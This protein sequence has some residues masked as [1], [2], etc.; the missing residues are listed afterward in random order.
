LPTLAPASDDTYW[1]YLTPDRT[2]I[3]IA[4]AASSIAVAIAV[5]ASIIKRLTAAMPSAGCLARAGTLRCQRQRPGI[6][7]SGNYQAF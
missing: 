3:T 6:D 5:H 2:I 4:A 1:S 7:C